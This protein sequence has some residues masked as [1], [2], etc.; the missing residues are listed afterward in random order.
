M[1]AADCTFGMVIASNLRLKY[2]Y[3]HVRSNHTNFHET[4]KYIIQ[5]MLP[6]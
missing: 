4:T 6:Y 3:E 2:K 5:N 1:R